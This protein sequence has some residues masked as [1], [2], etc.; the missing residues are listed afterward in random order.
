MAQII[1]QNVEKPV[2]I[3]WE[4]NGQ[5]FEKKITTFK[6]KVYN[7]EGQPQDIGKIG[8]GP[9]T[10]HVRLNLAKAFTGSV[11]LTW[12]LCRD[13]FTVLYGLV[14]G[15]MSLKA[16]GGPIFIAQAAGQTAKQGLTALLYFT[17]LLSVNLAILNILPI[18]VLDGGHLLF[19]GMEK[20]RKRPLSIKQRTVIQQ[21]GMGFLLVLILFITY[22]DIFRLFS[23]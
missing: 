13:I 4:R 1:Y 22:N 5:A 19:L 12:G 3:R 6:E 2:L 16:L 23:K 11:S 8:V 20:L 21:V 15:G 9:L 18:P 10:T 17:A 14:T 7:Q